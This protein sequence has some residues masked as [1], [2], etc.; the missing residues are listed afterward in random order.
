MSHIPETNP[1]VFR[2]TNPAVG[3]QLYAPQLTDAEF[4][5]QFTEWCARFAGT[6]EAYARVAPALGDT[7]WKLDR[8]FLGSIA[9]AFTGLYGIITDQDERIRTLE[10]QVAG[11][12]AP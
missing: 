12:L 9:A 11:L 1:G 7:Q 3:Q 2:P 5:E 4:R 8:K 6:E 10:E